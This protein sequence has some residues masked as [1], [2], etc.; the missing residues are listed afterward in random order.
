MDFGS[1]FGDSMNQGVSKVGDFLG[2]LA[3]T[4][5]N[6]M[7]LLNFGAQMFQPRAPG[8][9]TA[10]AVTGSLVQALALRD[11]LQIEAE[12]REQEKQKLASLLA[13]QG[14]QTQGS[15]ANTKQTQAQIESTEQTTKEK[16]DTYQDRLEADRVERKAKIAGAK[17]TERKARIEETKQSFLEAMNAEGSG[18]WAAVKPNLNAQERAWLAE[19]E[20]PGIANEQEQ[21]QTDFYKRQANAPYPIDRTGQTIETNEKNQERLIRGVRKMY[22]EEFEGMSE[23]DANDKAFVMAQGFSKNTPGTK[24]IVA[25]RAAAVSYTHLTLPTSD[26]V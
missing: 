16:R 21:A 26:L 12:K 1:L 4:P 24:S 14:A 9:S 25:E 5:E 6:R 2:G 22:P 23:E 10:G 19:L 11:Q 15:L 3:G 18:Y 7:A 8:Q 17:G 13:L 20:K